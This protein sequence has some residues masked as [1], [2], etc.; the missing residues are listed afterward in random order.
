MNQL[1]S[2]SIAFGNSSGQTSKVLLEEHRSRI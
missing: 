2:F 1:D